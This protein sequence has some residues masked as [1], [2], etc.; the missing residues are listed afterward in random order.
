M[1]RIYCIDKC[2]FFAAFAQKEKREQV[3]SSQTAYE[4]YIDAHNETHLKEFIELVSIPSISSIP[5]NKPD[6]DK[7]AAWI[8][9]KLKAIGI[10]TAQ[11]IATEGNPVVYGSWDKAP[12]K[13]TVLIYAHYDVQPVKESEWTIPPFSPK[14]SDGKYLDVEP[15]MIKVVC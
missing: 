7:A 3:K 12:G 10:T 8:V 9:N 2:I 6:V 4:A 5:A 11:T 1:Y 14:I 15:V 13:P